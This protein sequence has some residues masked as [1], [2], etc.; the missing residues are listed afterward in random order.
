MFL[1][2]LLFADERMTVTDLVKGKCEYTI[3]NGFLKI[4]SRKTPTFCS[5]SKEYI[6]YAVLLLIDF[7]NNIRYCKHCERNTNIV[8]FNV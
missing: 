2:S 6:L 8:V 4:T 5:L 3:I 7:V 1:T